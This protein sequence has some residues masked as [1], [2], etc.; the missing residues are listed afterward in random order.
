MLHMYLIVTRLRCLEKEG[1]LHWQAQLVDHFFHEAEDKMDLVHNISSR[2]I[3]QRYLK[4]LFHEW[5]G[6]ILAYDEGV[7]KGDAVLAAAVWRNLFKAREDVDL[8][9]LAAIVSWM[10]H[11]QRQ[12][13][14]MEDAAI[15]FHGTSAFKF[16]AKSELLVVDRPS[17]GLD[18]T[19]ASQLSQ[20]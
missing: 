12:L 6:L 19:L 8:R 7:V 3:R 15:M 2:M 10:R 17:Q 14:Q 18:G 11:S 20:N 13:D 5:R 1:F 9:S 4:D 16:P